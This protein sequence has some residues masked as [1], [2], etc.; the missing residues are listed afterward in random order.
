MIFDL[1]FII[2]I[3]ILACA[4]I[5][6]IKMTDV[7]T[8]IWGFTKLLFLPYVLYLLLIGELGNGEE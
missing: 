3:Q 7:P 4:C 5:H 6:A 2:L 1:V 8:S